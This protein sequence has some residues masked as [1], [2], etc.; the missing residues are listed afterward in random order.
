MNTKVVQLKNMTTRVPEDAVLLDD[1]LNQLRVGD[2][3]L[4]VRDNPK[5]PC[6]MEINSRT[7]AQVYGIDKERG[8]ITFGGHWTEA[9]D[10]NATTCTGGV[11]YLDK[12]KDWPFPHHIFLI[13]HGVVGTWPG[14]PNLKGNPGYDL[15]M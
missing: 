9:K 12:T 3:I 6:G 2:F 7:F 10:Y 1:A 8:S 14:P 13:R 15:M 5:F 4:E 11:A